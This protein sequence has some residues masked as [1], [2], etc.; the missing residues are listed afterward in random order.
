MICNISPVMYLT[1]RKVAE[2]RKRTETHKE[3]KYIK[4][5]R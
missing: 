3:T 5:I 1:S 4:A 2:N